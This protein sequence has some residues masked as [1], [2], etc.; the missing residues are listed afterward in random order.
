MDFARAAPETPPPVPLLRLVRRLCIL[1]VLARPINLMLL[2]VTGGL[3]GYLLYREDPGS[4]MPWAEAFW[5]VLSALFIMAGGYWLND[6][7]DVGIDTINRPR[8]AAQVRLLTRRRLMTAVI[9]LWSLAMLCTIPLWWTFKALHLLVI[10]A[11]FW[12]NR[13]GKRLGLPGNLLVA[14]LTALL[15]W[16]IMLLAARTAYAVSWMIPLAAVFNFAR[17]VV[18]DAEDSPGDL[19]H[20]IRTLPSRLSPRAWKIIL[21]IGWISLIVFTLVPAIVKYLLWK[22]IP[23]GYLLTVFLGAVLPLLG[24]LFELSDYRR[25]SRLL[26][27]AMVGGLGALIFL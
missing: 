17:E 18:K 23:V 2:A 19:S 21:R 9:L 15:P 6:L 22:T 4:S 16:E 20:G 14:A 7:Y 24:G 26:K 5:L 27:L 8:R 13:Y 3:A 12:Y 1:L 11:L 25:L 10:L